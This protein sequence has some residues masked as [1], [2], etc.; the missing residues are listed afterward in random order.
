MI[1]VNYVYVVIFNNINKNQDTGLYN[2]PKSGRAQ[3]K[4]TKI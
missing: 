3:L 4:M 2:L 1:N